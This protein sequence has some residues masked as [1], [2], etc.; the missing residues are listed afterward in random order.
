MIPAESGRYWST[1]SA[2]RFKFTNQGEIALQA[3]LLQ[4]QN[5]HA[6]IH[7]SVR[8]TGIGISADKQGLI[9]DAFAQEDS[10][11]TRKYGGTGLGLSICRR[12]VELM[13]GRMWAA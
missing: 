7:F 1:W 8:D 10:S 11:T 5:D 4:L 3:D 13:G 2:T 9:F 12:L 6:V